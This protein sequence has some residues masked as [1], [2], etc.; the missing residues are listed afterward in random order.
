MTIDVHI[1]WWKR[2]FLSECWHMVE[3][4][5]VS[6]IFERSF[7]DVWLNDTPQWWDPEG[8]KIIHRMDEAGVE[9]SVVMPLD[10]GLSCGEGDL[11][12]EEQNKLT[13]DLA[14]KYPDRIVP[15]C[16]VDPR[17]DYALDLIDK[18]VNE[19]GAKGFKVYNAGFYPNDEICYPIYER[20]AKLN[21][22]IMFHI[23]V[24][25]QPPMDYSTCHPHDLEPVLKEFPNVRFCAPHFGYPNMR[26]LIS[27][28]RKYTN[29]YTDMSGTHLGLKFGYEDFAKIMRAFIDSFGP[30][31]VMFGTDAPWAEPEFK[32]KVAIQLIKDLPQADL[33]EAQFT[34][35]EIQKVLHDNA[36]KYLGS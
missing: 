28:G 25:D 18:C 6:K 31:R 29:L 1:H 32:T 17:R 26:E 4:L 8:L 10:F 5:D 16:S 19:W 33:K 27:L 24:L 23:G 30:D 9:K 13:C 36:L 35:E 11:S 22:P 2:E 20:A 14:N 15:F 21:M 34:E 12:I 7:E 3:A